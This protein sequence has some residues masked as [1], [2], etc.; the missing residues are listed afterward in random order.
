MGISVVIAELGHAPRLQNWCSQHLARRSLAML[1]GAGL[2]AW[3]WW[4]TSW[5]G[6]CYCTP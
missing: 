1:I 4:A 3:A 6:L 2:T 5:L